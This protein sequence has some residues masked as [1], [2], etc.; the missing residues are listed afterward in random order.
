MPNIYIHE[1]SSS[2]MCVPA[3]L[4]MILSRRGFLKHSQSELA[5]EL[6]LTVPQDMSE[7]YPGAKV[8]RIKTEWGVHPQSREHSLSGL[9]DKLNVPLCYQFISVN[10][11]VSSEVESFMFENLLRGND[12]IV[13]YSY[14]SVFGD[15]ENVGHVS[16]I[17]DVIKAQGKVH[18]VDPEIPET[19]EVSVSSLLKGVKDKHDGFWLF[20]EKRH[21]LYLMPF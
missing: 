17:S 20:A 14:R 4:N 10:E 15:G 1:H 11:I 8:S 18:L 9:L 3:C 21:D 7:M 12:I 13:G 6:G 16:L 5:Y 2:L 19:R